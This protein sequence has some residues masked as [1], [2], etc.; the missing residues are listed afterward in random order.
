[1]P[2]CKPLAVCLCCLSLSLSVCLSVCVSLSV[3][4]IAHC[5]SVWPLSWRCA[6]VAQSWMLVPSSLC[7]S[8]SVLSASLCVSLFFSVPVCLHAHATLSHAGLPT[9]THSQQRVRTRPPARERRALK[10]R[11]VRTAMRA[12]TVA[13][14]RCVVCLS[15][16]LSLCA[17][18]SQSFAVCVCFCEQEGYYH[19]DQITCR[20]CGTRLNDLIELC[21]T[22]CVTATLFFVIAAVCVC[23]RE[24]CCVR[25]CACS[26]GCSREC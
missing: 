13:R 18:V 6:C 19:D 7:L 20:Q 1:M 3:C 12:S 14:A 11:C 9:K 22:L 21:I 16:C 17:S 2:S 25:V 4:V 8:V 5:C 23:V 26:R 10:R 15:L 24:R